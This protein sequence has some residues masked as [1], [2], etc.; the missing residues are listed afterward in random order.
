MLYPISIIPNICEIYNFQSKCLDRRD[1]QAGEHS[2]ARFT[3]IDSI[4]QAL[5]SAFDCRALFAHPRP[6]FWR[7]A[8][9]FAFLSGKPRNLKLLNPYIESATG[10]N[11]LRCG[12]GRI[13]PRL[14]ILVTSNP[15]NTSTHGHT[16]HVLLSQVQ[17]DDSEESGVPRRSGQFATDCCE[18]SWPLCYIF[19]DIQGRDHVPAETLIEN[20]L[21]SARQ[22]ECGLRIVSV[23]HLRQPPLSYL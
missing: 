16:L 19:L 7:I 22:L 8:A 3:G 17:E 1:A 10:D 12:S 2:P 18:P 15:S 6:G 21:S 9:I 11:A 13:S 4:R 5:H 20:L 23:Y 14:A